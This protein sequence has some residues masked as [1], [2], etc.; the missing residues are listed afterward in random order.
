MQMKNLIVRM[1][2]VGVMLSCVAGSAAE[3]QNVQQL[4]KIEKYVAQRRQE[5]ED[6]YLS[7]TTDL[8]LRAEAAI[9]LLEVADMTPAL[10]VFTKWAESAEVELAE[11]VLQINGFQ[12]MLYGGFETTTETPARRFAVA[13]SRIA[14][15]KNGI[16]R[17]YRQVAVDLEKQKR[18][19]LTVE[20]AQV[21]KRL[22]ENVRAPAPRPTRGEVTAILYAEDNPTAV[23][24][25]KIVHEADT[26][27]GVKVAKIR[28]DNVEFVKNRNRWRQKVRQTPA[29]FWQ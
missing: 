15:L 1:F 17:R 8:Q 22:K 24:D 9:R 6:Y 5:I 23:I 7:V 29:A 28:P 14:Q 16:L 26:I 4:E 11:T 21:E 20:L 27:H 19:A 10:A 3:T 12:N 2:I 13:Q 18:Y 25:G